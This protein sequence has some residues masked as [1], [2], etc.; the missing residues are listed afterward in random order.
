VFSAKRKVIFVHGCFWHHHD[1]C[2]I[3]KIPRTRTEFW[4]AKFERNRRRDHD[5]LVRIRESGWE[6]FVVWECEAGRPD[7]LDRLA[8]FLGPVRAEDVPTTLGI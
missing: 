8:D 7:L 3:A 6:P 1:N 2:Q 5:Q 4:K